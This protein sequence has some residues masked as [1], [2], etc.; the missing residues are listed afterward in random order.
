[1][2]S[3]LEKLRLKIMKQEIPDD[4]NDDEEKTRGQ[5]DITDLQN[6]YSEELS[7][8]N[9]IEEESTEDINFEAKYNDIKQSE[10]DEELKIDD[11]EISLDKQ[12]VN[13]DFP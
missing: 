7:K 13:F 10:I 2:E 6:T 3:D 8:I 11:A 9:K 4:A 5:Q 12:T 1:M